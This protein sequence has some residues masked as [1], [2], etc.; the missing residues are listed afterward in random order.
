MVAYCIVGVALPMPWGHSLG[1]ASVGGIPGDSR[2]INLHSL[3]K[4]H[5]DKVFYVGLQKTGT[6]SFFALTKQLGLHTLHDTWGIYNTLHFPQHTLCRG[7]GPSVTPSRCDGACSCL[8]SAP[9]AV[10]RNLW[11]APP[12][13]ERARQDLVTPTLGALIDGFDAFGDHPWP[14]LLPWL[15][16]ALPKARFVLWP[17][18]SA[19]WVKS[20]I[21]Y[22]G[23]GDEKFHRTSSTLLRRGFMLAYGECFVTNRSTA[24]L[25]RSYE[26]HTRVALKLA[27]AQPERWLVINFTALDAAARVCRFVLGSAT[28]GGGEHANERRCAQY[29]GRAMPQENVFASRKSNTAAATQG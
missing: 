3:Q 29:E 13:Y 17:R 8:C 10:G 16:A 15:M 21:S 12:H 20:V 18:P 22:N 26:R 24:A 14:F 5:G 19:E 23:H 11:G 6:T 7:S 28:R 25:L 9:E 2:T 4:R 1:L 27:A